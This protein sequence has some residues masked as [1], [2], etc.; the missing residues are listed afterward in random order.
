MDD[1]LAYIPQ[2]PPF[3]MI[4]ELVAVDEFTGTTRFRVREDNIFVEHGRLTEPAMIEN[5]AQTAAARIGYI[6]AG[7]NEPPPVGFI[8]AVQ[9]LEIMALPEVGQ[10][11]QTRIAIKNQ[12]LN[13]TVI[14]GEIRHKNEVLAQCEMKIFIRETQISKA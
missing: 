11:L 13:V 8:G 10:T 5:I 1:I 4:D 6:F 2:R 12:I 14:S 7:R 3:V 9:K